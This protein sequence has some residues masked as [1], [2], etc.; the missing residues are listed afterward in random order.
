MELQYT[1]QA[2]Q[3]FLRIV[4]IYGEFSGPIS[5]NKFIEKVTSVH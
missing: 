3:E 2:K 5:A 4:E 1:K